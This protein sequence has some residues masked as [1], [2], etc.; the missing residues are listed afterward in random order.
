MTSPVRAIL[1]I[2]ETVDD[3]KALREHVNRVLRSLQDGSLLLGGLRLDKQRVVPTAAPGP[4]ESNLRLVMDS[5]VVTLYV[6]NGAAW[7][8]VGT[9]T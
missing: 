2:P 5:G 8:V 3:P 9:Q 1:E 6:Y 7:V 4:R